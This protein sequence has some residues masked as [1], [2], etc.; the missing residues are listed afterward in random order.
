MRT[1]THT[2]LWWRKPEGRRPTG[3]SRRGCEY[4]IKIDVKRKMR[5]WTRFVWLRTGATGKWAVV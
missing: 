3:R 4:N 1:E 2:E 5:L